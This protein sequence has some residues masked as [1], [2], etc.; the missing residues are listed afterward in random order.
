MPLVKSE[1]NRSGVEPVV[2]TLVVIE[3]DVADVS[4]VAENDSV[5]VPAVPP[6]ERFVN[7]A[8]PFALVVA[9]VVPANVPVP[10]PTAAVTVTP[11]CAT[12]L[13][14]ASRS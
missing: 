5:R 4:P 13:P 6:I 9:V 12:L 2:T 1:K 11:D 3:F 10:D 14:A 8:A 7:A